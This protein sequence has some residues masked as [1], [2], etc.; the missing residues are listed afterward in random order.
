MVQRDN[1]LK[2]GSFSGLELSK[3]KKQ[4]GGGGRERAL[5]LWLSMPQSNDIMIL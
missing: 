5:L 1:V 3:K 4:E 2:A